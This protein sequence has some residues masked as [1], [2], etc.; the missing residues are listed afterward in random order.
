M[1]E[2]KS[3]ARSFCVPRRCRCCTH[4]SAGTRQHAATPRVGRRRGAARLD[5]G[6]VCNKHR[7]VLA[8][9][10][11]II[12]SCSCYYLRSLPTRQNVQAP[13]A[14]QQAALQQF[15]LINQPDQPHCTPARVP[16]APVHPTMTFTP[17][18]SCWLN[19]SETPPPSA[20]QSVHSE[21]TGTFTVQDGRQNTRSQMPLLLQ[22]A[23]HVHH[24]L[25]NEAQL[26][27]SSAATMGAVVS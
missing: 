26:L 8:P 16:C 3:L 4:C 19:R 27:R 13:G 2:L 10:A 20:A 15:Q 24:A 1:L 7:P 11:C 17:K 22:D 21:I 12:G 25:L 5:N 6:R 23:L 9:T 14:G 18:P